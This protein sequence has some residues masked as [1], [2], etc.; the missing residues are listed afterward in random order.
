MTL[1]LILD[2]GELIETTDIN[3]ALDPA[4]ASVFVS[5]RNRKT[6]LWVGDESGPRKRFI[7]AR[8]AQGLRYTS[9]YPIEHDTPADEIRQAYEAE[10]GAM[11]SSSIDASTKK[12]T[13]AVVKEPETPPKEE[14]VT[15]SSAPT[16]DDDTLLSISHKL[17]DLKPIPGMVRD[18]IV[19][20]GRLMTLLETEGGILDLY[21]VSGMPDGSFFVEHY[22]PRILLEGD[23]V[24]AVELWR[25]EDE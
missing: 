20:E 19:V 3:D 25:R 1:Y 21:P 13:Q 2:D 6:Y 23:L 14:K 8:A 11:T 5:T 17:A 16:I 22:C 10:L 15:K 4:N 9:G 12:Q 24:M 18:Y 7:G